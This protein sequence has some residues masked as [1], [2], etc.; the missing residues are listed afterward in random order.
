[1]QC[2]MF[3]RVL[4]LTVGVNQTITPAASCNTVLGDSSFIHHLY[5]DAHLSCL[6]Q[7]LAERAVDELQAIIHTLVQK[8]TTS[9][10]RTKVQP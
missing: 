5:T 7:A 10:Q 1:M 8:G 4:F 9:A 2:S 6:P 3:R